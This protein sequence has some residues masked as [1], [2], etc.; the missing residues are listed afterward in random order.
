[1]L[2]CK[3]G[4]FQQRSTT[5][6]S[7][8]WQFLMHRACQWW[9]FPWCAQYHHPALMSPTASIWSLSMKQVY[10]AAFVLF[11]N[12]HSQNQW[13]WFF[14]KIKVSENL[15]LTTLTVDPSLT[16]KTTCSVRLM[17][18]SAT[19]PLAFPLTHTETETLLLLGAMGSCQEGQDTDAEQPIQVQHAA[20]EH[21]GWWSRCL[22]ERVTL[23]S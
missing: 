13:H 22:Q 10:L 4:Q 9:R 14:W 1:M 18:V 6:V 3:R 15:V 23:A 21:D 5:T 17:E 19:S 11:W 8:R 16:I 12:L 20:Q 2:F 7:K